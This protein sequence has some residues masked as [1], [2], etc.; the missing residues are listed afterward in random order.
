MKDFLSQE[1]KI[2]QTIVT[3]DSLGTQS[4]Q[5]RKGEVIG[6]TKTFVVLK[7]DLGIDTNGIA[8]SNVTKRSPEKVVIVK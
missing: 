4:T 7:L 6:F 5:L 3:I 2:G 1:L 8:R